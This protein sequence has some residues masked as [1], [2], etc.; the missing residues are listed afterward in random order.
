MVSLQRAL[1]RLHVEAVWGVQLPLMLQDNIELL[2]ESPQPSWKL[3]AAEMDT[4]RVSVW[5]SDVSATEREDLLVRVN[6][7]LALPPTVSTAP[8]ISREIALHQVALPTMSV[9]AAHMLARP[10]TSHDQALVETFEPDSVAYYFHPGRRPLIGVIVEGRLLSLAHSSRRTAEACELGIDTLPEAR[11]KGYALAATI[12]WAASV[13]QEELV[14]L[15][16][17]FAD[18]TASLRLAVAAGYRAF[19]RAATIE[20]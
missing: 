11:R 10:L 8:G 12:L 5:R 2:S 15:Y 19:A 7:A 3:Y 14:P 20:Q 9:A 13:A 4:D 18:N 6:E 16:S 17:A 1:L